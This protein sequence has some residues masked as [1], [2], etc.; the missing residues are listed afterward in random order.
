[1]AG[2]SLPPASRR[3]IDDDLALID[4]LADPVARLDAHGVGELTALVILAEVGDFSRFAYE[5]LNSAR[6][7]PAARDRWGG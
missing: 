1:L 3:V 4:A 2:L 6:A 7:S 5:A